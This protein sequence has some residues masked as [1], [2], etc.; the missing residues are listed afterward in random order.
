M[1][2]RQLEY[3]QMV[4]KTES[5][6]KAAAL[7]NVSQPTITV[8]VKKLE[9]ELQV[10]L[11]ERNGKHLKLTHEGELFLTRADEILARIQYSVA[12]MN[13][14]HTE[15]ADTIK[16][17]ITPIAG[18]VIFPDIFERINSQC[19]HFQ[20]EFTEEGSLA[21]QALLEKGELDLGI[22]IF[23]AELKT[24]ETI[25]IAVEPIHV[26]FA[27][28]HPLNDRSVVAFEQLQQH[29]FLVFKEDTYSRQLV[30][31]ECKKHRFTPKVVFASRQVE[32]I[33]GLVEAGAGI[34]F[35]PQRIIQKHPNIGSCPLAEPI[36]IHVGIAWNKGKYLSKAGQRFIDFIKN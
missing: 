23:P 15:A 34:S 32:T 13:D 11:F 31:D 20:A 28:S 30:F 18:A 24:L 14:Y 26:C 35:L 17:G 6:Q 8:A 9:E 19:P 29:P 10:Q 2:L 36:A 5:M 27:K 33:I 1:Q 12:E 25:T 3:F 21:I 7:L 4:G 22:L 16:I